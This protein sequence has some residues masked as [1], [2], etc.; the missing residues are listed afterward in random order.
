MPN[1]N[2]MLDAMVA[3]NNAVAEAGDVARKARDIADVAQARVLDAS[4][5]ADL[6]RRACN[7][8]ARKHGCFQYHD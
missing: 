2:D 3:A 7:E 4:H 8:Y 1:M 5:A 6:A